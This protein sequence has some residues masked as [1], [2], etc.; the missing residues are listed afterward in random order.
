MQSIPSAGNLTAQVYDLILQKGRDGLPPGGDGAT[1]KRMS[2]DNGTNIGTSLVDPNVQHQFDGRQRVTV[3]WIPFK[4]DHGDVFHSQLVV[5][6]PVRRDCQKRLVVRATQEGTDIARISDS[7]TVGE[8][9][10]GHAEDCL[11]FHFS[12]HSCL[13]V[14]VIVA[15]IIPWIPWEMDTRL[16]ATSPICG[17]LTLPPRCAQNRA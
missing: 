15:T 2:V 16:Q 9:R 6:S 17:L 12:D 8:E 11:T 10:L 7:Q 4:I 13:S 5:V 1:P 3:E 14:V